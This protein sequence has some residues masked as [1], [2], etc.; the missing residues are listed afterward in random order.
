[1]ISVK[2]AFET[3]IAQVN[4]FP[5]ELC[6][7][8]KSYGRVLAEDIVADRDLP[9]FHRVAMD[10]IAIAL[11]AWHKGQKSFVIEGTQGAGSPCVSL[12]NSEGCWEIMTGAVLPTGC[13]CVIPVEYLKIE[14]NIAHV[15]EEIQL[16]E[17]TNVHQQASD[18]KS[19]SKLIS[20]GQ[21]IEAHHISVIA[22]VG[23]Y[24]VEV[25]RIPRIA[26][27]ATG[28]ELVAVDAQV[29]PYQIRMSNTYA[30]ESGLH[31]H[32]FDQTMIFH[33]KDDKEQLHNKLRDILQ[34]FDVL[35][36]SGGVSK[37]K[38]DYVPEVL[39]SLG[40]ELKFRRVQQRP[41]K[42]L[43]FGVHTTTNKPVFAIPGNP[44]TAIT[45]FRHYVVPYLNKCCSLPQRPSFAVLKS[46]F[47]FRKN[48]TYFLP[49]KIE[50][51]QGQLVADPCPTAGSGDYASLIG[52]HGYVKLD[53]NTNY[54]AK[55]TLVPF[56]PW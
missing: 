49:V 48:L 26:I 51:I 1:M 23:K 39:D 41:G 24:E 43:T 19:G 6:V 56:Y 47:N 44:V 14:N 55:Q 31:K 40:V 28:D 7:F 53:A 25:Y 27:I 12:Q 15:V 50:N 18:Y 11:S 36:L 38:Y 34:D 21:R 8:D 30:I 42:P 22:S 45:N 54:F 17:M 37:G 29:A 5:K 46:D 13:D 52:T 33:L 10:G 9:P 32:G 35:I 20:E 2:E 4:E 3:I 16:Q